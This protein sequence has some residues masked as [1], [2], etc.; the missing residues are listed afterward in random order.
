MFWQ[1][2]D[3]IAEEPN[4]KTKMPKSNPRILEDEDTEGFKRKLKIY[5]TEFEIFLQ[6]KLKPRTIYQHLVVIGNLIDFL[7]FDCNVNSF[8]E[9][10]R[11]MVCS[12]S[13]MV[14]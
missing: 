9:I 12:S 10:R 7:C 1:S 11:S 13:E 8:E 4:D 2:G 6:P 14:L 5:L 3:K